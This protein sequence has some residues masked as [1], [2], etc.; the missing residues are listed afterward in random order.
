MRLTYWNIKTRLYVLFTRQNTPRTRSEQVVP[1]VSNSSTCELRSRSNATATYMCPLVWVICQFFEIRR[2][3]RCTLLNGHV[4]IAVAN[5]VLAV[6]LRTTV[7]W[8]HVWKM[9]RARDVVQLLHPRTSQHTQGMV[10]C[11]RLLQ[12]M[13]MGIICGSRA[14]IGEQR[15]GIN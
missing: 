3:N 10:Y 13:I 14:F 5:R 15:L 7:D 4:Y 11:R 1:M 12:F 6:K 2:R 8:K 9:V